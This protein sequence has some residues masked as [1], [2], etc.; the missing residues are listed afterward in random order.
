M[1]NPDTALATLRG[2][3]RQRAGRPNCRNGPHVHV[4]TVGGTIAH[5]LVCYG[6]LAPEGA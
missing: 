3:F 4:A 1:G 6:K 2:R 5:H